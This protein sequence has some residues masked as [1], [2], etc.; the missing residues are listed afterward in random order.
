M[1][2]YTV[3]YVSM[4]QQTGRSETCSS[5]LHAPACVSVGRDCHVHTYM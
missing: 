4:N 3:V 5:T 1:E 2:L